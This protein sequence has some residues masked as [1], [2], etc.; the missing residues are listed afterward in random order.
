MEISDGK[1]S[2][3]SSLPP[4][5]IRPVFPKKSHFTSDSVETT[6]SLCCPR[7]SAIQAVL[8]LVRVSG[9][10]EVR[11]ATHVLRF[12]DYFI[13]RVKF[14]MAPC[15]YEV[16]LRVASHEEPANL[17]NHPLKYNITTGESCP[18]LLISMEHPLK[19]KF[20]YV[21]QPPGT[22]QYGITVVAP[23]NYRVR[24]GHAYFLIHLDM[25]VAKKMNR[26]TP[27]E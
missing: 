27:L 24:V 25:E 2:H 1:D 20:G 8:C 22:Q 26:I 18:N 3:M 13:I 23:T 5:E 12:N 11:H 10:E 15:K 17:L 4:P 16:S 14:P 7:A 9:K 6:I 19:D 21:N